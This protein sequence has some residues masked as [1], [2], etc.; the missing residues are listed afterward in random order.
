MKNWKAI[1]IPLQMMELPKD[2]RGYPIPFTIERD[3]S[4]KPN[5]SN[6]DPKRIAES[7]KNK[8]C[9][10]CGKPLNSDVWLL[11]G[12]KIAFSPIGAYVD[13]PMHK[14]CATYALKVCPYLA[15][16]SFSKRSP[17]GVKGS[18]QAIIVS[19]RPIVFALVK[20]FD[21]R[22]HVLPDKAI[23]ILPFRPFLDIEFWKDGHQISFSEANMLIQKS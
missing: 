5:F 15:M 3:A 9:S 22:L 14:Q 21:F 7:I 17:N 12:A 10:I 1:E 16:P 6:H 19:G 4:G 20:T 23:V 18:E 2:D 13:P 11:A 8:R